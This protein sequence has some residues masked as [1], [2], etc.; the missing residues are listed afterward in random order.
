MQNGL[1]DTQT[2]IFFAKTVQDIYESNGFN[3]N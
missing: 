3:S 1:L 2:P